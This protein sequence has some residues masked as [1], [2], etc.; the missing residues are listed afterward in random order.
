MTIGSVEL[1]SAVVL[2]PMAGITDLPFRQLAY[3]YGAGMV[4]AEMLTA[5]KRL[6]NSR[7]SRLRLAFGD[8]TGPRVVQIAG[9]DAAMLADAARQV[10]DLGAEII[11]INMGCPAKKVCNKAAGSALMKD[12]RLVAKIFEEVIASV[13]VPVT[14]KTRTGWSPE[15]KN[16]VRVAELAELSGI[17]AITIH[18]RTRSCRFQGDVDYESITRVKQAVS[19]PVIANGDID[20]AEKAEQ[21][22]IKTGAD[23]VMIGR[24][25]LGQ[26]WIAGNIAQFL[27]KGLQLR[28]PSVQDVRNLLLEHLASLHAFYD[29]FL[30]TRIARK[31]VA[32]YLQRLPHSESFRKEFNGINSA[33]EQKLRLAEFFDMNRK[34]LEEGFAA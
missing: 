6:W 8:D 10:V 30:G 9:G 21:I 24:A 33:E 22:L 13:D 32:W 17:S 27:H 11:D 18:G 25:A 5:D 4:V 14:V 12:E 16:A 26:P 28:C 19:I 1:P 15:H 29:E 34:K 23:G 3:R 20:S 7:K 31:H 2:A